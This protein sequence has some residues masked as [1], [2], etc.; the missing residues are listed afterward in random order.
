MYKPKNDHSNTSYFDCKLDKLKATL[1]KAFPFVIQNISPGKDNHLILSN[2]SLT[3]LYD[4]EQDQI[5]WQQEVPGGWT[6]AAHHY[7]YKDKIIKGFTLD[8]FTVF[9]YE[10]GE[11]VTKQNSCYANLVFYQFSPS[12]V[13]FDKRRVLSKTTIT[14]SSEKHQK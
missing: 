11:Y 10:T 14:N 2:S 12:L 5:L 3:V 9:D 6:Y 7:V 4:V 8:A 1:K 13:F